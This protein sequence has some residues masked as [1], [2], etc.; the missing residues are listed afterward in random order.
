MANPNVIDYATFGKYPARSTNNYEL[1]TNNY[2]SVR[3]DGGEYSKGQTFLDAVQALLDQ[4]LW[5]QFPDGAYLNPTQAAQ[6]YRAAQGIQGLTHILDRSAHSRGL[7]KDYD[8]EP[9]NLLSQSQESQLR[10]ALIEISA[11]LV[12]LVDN[13]HSRATE[14]TW[15]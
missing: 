5:P 12:N 10:F 13:L 6:L 4:P 15:V 3:E 11:E 7:S 9:D 14:N 1:T 2:L 8:N